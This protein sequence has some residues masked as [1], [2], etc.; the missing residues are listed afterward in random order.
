MPKYAK[1]LISIAPLILLGSS[2]AVGSGDFSAFASSRAPVF[3][4]ASSFSVM[5]ES[6]LSAAATASP[7]YRGQVVNYALVNGPDGMSIV[8]TTGQLIWTPRHDQT[9]NP[10][11]L[12]NVTVKAFD[13][14]NPRAFAT[15][16][17]KIKVVQVNTKPSVSCA[18]NVSVALGEKLLLQVQGSDQDIGQRLKYSLRGAPRG[19]AVGATS[20]VLSWTPKK[21][22]KGSFTFA[23]VATDNGSPRLSAEAQITVTVGNANRP[24]TLDPIAD[25][26]ASPGSPLTFTTSASDPDA[27]Q[28]LSFSLENAPQGA[29]INASTGK[30]TWTPTAEQARA[31]S[32]YQFTVRVTDDGSPALSDQKVVKVTLQTVA[33]TQTIPFAGAPG[34]IENPLKGWVYQAPYD[35]GS[36]LFRFISWKELEPS[37]GYFDFSSLEKWLQSGTNAN[38]HL[39]FRVY[40]D[41]PGLEPGVPKWLTDR[42]VALIPYPADPDGN[43]GYTPDYNH[44]QLVSRLVRLIEKLG[45]RF[46]GDPRVAFIQ[47]G[48]MGQYGEWTTYRAGNVLRYSTATQKAILDAYDRAF[49]NKKLQGRHAGLSYDPTAVSLGANYPIGFHDDMFPYQTHKVMLP[50]L[51]SKGKAEAWKS[52]PMGGELWPFREDLMLSDAYTDLSI[53]RSNSTQFVSMAQPFNKGFIGTKWRVLLGSGFAGQDITIVDVNE[54][55]VATADK[56]LGNLGASGG[57]MQFLDETGKAW[58]CVYEMALD[59]IQAFRPTYMRLLQHLVTNT[60]PNTYAKLCQMARMMGY[61]FRIT[62]MTLPKELAIGRDNAI[63]LNLINEGVAPFYYKWKVSLALMQGDVVRQKFEVPWDI[64]NWLPGAISESCFINPTVGAGT[65]DLAIKIEDP[66][67]QA[68]KPGIEFA[69]NLRFDGNGWTHLA[70]VTLK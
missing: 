63:Q 5:E 69:N 12:Y 8:G 10:A 37:E 1:F 48:I 49:P 35:G 11:K 52:E 25:K 58:N 39:V 64:R 24:P 45:E 15:K 21:G 13:A 29:A 50:P 61:Q 17:L 30:F 33:D 44:P 2:A 9:S 43:S 60:R 16:N 4:C 19:A 53:S 14:A 57:R 59:R 32:T 3:R 18:S 66:W 6:A 55:G 34:P 56:P 54:S 42:G 65:Y 62:S 26:T 68:K 31:S 20:G 38:K 36:M 67:S 46:D 28:K 22:Q 40:L 41:Y 70:Q 51:K 7:G 47:I 23:V 27:G